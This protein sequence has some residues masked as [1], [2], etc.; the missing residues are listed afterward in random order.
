LGDYSGEFEY[1]LRTKNIEYWYTLERNASLTRVTADTLKIQFRDTAYADVAVYFTQR[2]PFLDT[3]YYWD[4]DLKSLTLHGIVVENARHTE[5]GTLAGALRVIDE[6]YDITSGL[7]GERYMHHDDK[8]HSVH[9]RTERYLPVE[10][11]APDTTE[12]T[13]FR[14]FR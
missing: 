11:N 8:Q 2:D 1:D 14:G 13:F 3:V 7:T 10:S 6:G 4:I 5:P 9:M 12:T